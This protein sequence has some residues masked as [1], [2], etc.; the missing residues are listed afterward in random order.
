MCTSLASVS[1]SRCGVFLFFLFFFYF[2]YIYFRWSIQLWWLLKA[3]GQRA[4][5]GNS[6][7]KL[8][9][10][11]KAPLILMIP[12]PMGV[13]LSS[14]I[15][16]FSFFYSLRQSSFRCPPPP[17]LSFLLVSS[18]SFFVSFSP[19]P[20]FYTIRFIFVIFIMPIRPS[21]S[22]R[23]ILQLRGARRITQSAAEYSL[24]SSRCF[25]LTSYG[26]NVSDAPRVTPPTRSQD[27]PVKSGH[28]ASW[29][30]LL[31]ILSHAFLHHPI[32]NTMLRQQ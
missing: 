3:S 9:K 30:L 17:S 16:F 22:I 18:S 2:L 29:P 26:W 23:G 19:S 28:S 31:N 5:I 14:A 12:R 11:A 10:S 13:F 15:L 7:S 32:E 27:I 1:C 4:D 8:S 20:A 21:C 24:P 6:A 25:S